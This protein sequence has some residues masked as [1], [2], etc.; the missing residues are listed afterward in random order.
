MT[1]RAQDIAEFFRSG[2]HEELV[3]EFGLCEQAVPA[4]YMVLRNLA[5]GA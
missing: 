1:V 3:R 2:D 4:Q 5:A